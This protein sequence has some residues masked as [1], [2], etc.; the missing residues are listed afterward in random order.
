M[1]KSKQPLAQAIVQLCEY[2]N[3]QHIVI[4]PGS[5]NAPL[6]IG[7]TNHEFFECYSIVDERSAGFFALG[8]AQQL[9]QPVALVCTSGSALVNYYPSVTEAFYSRVPLVVISADRPEHLINIGDGQ[10]ITQPHIFGSHILLEANLKDHFKKPFL[11]T[12]KNN[13][14]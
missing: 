14:I 5:R 12:V 13:N 3:I 6:T 7:F 10:T 11:K 4:S 9:Q 1:I 2:H 8:M